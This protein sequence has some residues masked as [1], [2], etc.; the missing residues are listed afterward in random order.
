MNVSG[1]T[2]FSMGRRLGPTYV[3]ATQDYLEAPVSRERNK[4]LVSSCPERIILEVGARLDKNNYF[5]HAPVLEF[6]RHVRN[7]VAHD[8]RFNVE[9]VPYPAEFDGMTIDEDTVGR[10][11]E[12][13][14]PGDLMALVDAV[15]D[16]VRSQATTT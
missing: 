13:F 6:L 16:H 12:R 9:R 11:D 3:M 4:L 1:D 14:L 15:A 5:D 8:G 2:Q 7:C 10:L